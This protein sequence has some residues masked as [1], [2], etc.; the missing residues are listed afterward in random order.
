MSTNLISLVHECRLH[1]SQSP[2]LLSQIQD[3]IPVKKSN[4]LVYFFQ[5]IMLIGKNYMKWII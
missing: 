2:H 3:D 5:K 1:T 4:Q